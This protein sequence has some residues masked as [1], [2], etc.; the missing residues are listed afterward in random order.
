MRDRDDLL[1]ADPVVRELDARG[2]VDGLEQLLRPEVLQQD[3]HGGQ[4]VC[5][6][7]APPIPPTENATITLSQPAMGEANQIAYLTVEWEDDS[8]KRKETRLLTV[9]IRP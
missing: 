6:V 4:R 2:A 8:G 1:G 5:P 3:E 7:N 9:S